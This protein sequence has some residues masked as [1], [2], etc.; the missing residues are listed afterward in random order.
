MRTVQKRNFKFR[1]PRY[2]PVT[3]SRDRRTTAESG[4]KRRSSDCYFDKWQVGEKE[5]DSPV[6]DQQS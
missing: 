2:F 6:R 5:Q 3:S 4:E 1:T